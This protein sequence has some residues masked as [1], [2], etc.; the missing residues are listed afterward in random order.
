M[1]LNGRYYVGGIFLKRPAWKKVF[2][3]NV[4]CVTGENYCV[5]N[6]NNKPHIAK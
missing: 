1:V 6:L 4:E 5:K 2:G 3:R